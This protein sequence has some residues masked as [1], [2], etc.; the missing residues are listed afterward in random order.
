M[1]LILQVLLARDGDYIRLQ[2]ERVGGWIQ[3]WGYPV[4]I[5]ELFDFLFSV[6]ASIR[7]FL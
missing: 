7:F 4:R 1:C 2:F 3:K 6:F 5:W